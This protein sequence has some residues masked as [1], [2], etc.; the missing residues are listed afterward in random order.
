MTTTSITDAPAAQE[1]PIYPSLAALRLAHSKLLSGFDRNNPSAAMIAEQLATPST[2]IL[3]VSDFTITT[4]PDGLLGVPGQYVAKA[5][6]TD[7]AGV[8]GDVE[9]FANARDARTRLSALT[10]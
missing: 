10:G 1:L 3:R 7:S 6:F 4:D 8:T 5:Q 9:V 2:V